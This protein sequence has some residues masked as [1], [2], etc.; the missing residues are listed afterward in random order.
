M[1]LKPLPDQPLRLLHLGDSYTIGEGVNLLDNWPSQFTRLL[2]SAGYTV[3]ASKV[4]A[5]TGWTSADLLEALDEIILRP[6][7][8]FV[9]LCIGVNNQYQERC[10]SEFRNDLGKLIEIGR[11]LL[12]EPDGQLCILSIPDWSVT[13][14]AGERNRAKISSEIDSFN[15]VLRETALAAQLSFVDWTDLTRKLGKSAEAFTADGLHPGSRQYGDWARYLFER[16]PG[17]ANDSCWQTS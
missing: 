8:D 1:N 4:I 14:F 6:A 12:L 10:E 11:S 17:L 15:T 7:W 5:R 3:D 13:P 16:F 9:T 2:Q